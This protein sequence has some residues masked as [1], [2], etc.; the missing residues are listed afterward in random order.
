MT[1]RE[2][3][4]MLS[5][6][7]WDVCAMEQLAL[8]IAALTRERLSGRQAG[9]M[10]AGRDP[11]GREA[12]APRE[13]AELARMTA[14][15]FALLCGVRRVQAYVRLLPAREQFVLVRRDLW[16]MDWAL[17]TAAY[18]QTVPPEERRQER[19]LRRDRLA[20]LRRLAQNMEALRQGKR[21]PAAYL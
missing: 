1:T 15:L 20:A 6:Y 12:V 8:D 14:R 17:V 9:A 5:L 21:P 11:T 10:A 18:N 3:E 19:T 16:G 13:E 7:R 2:V 4:E